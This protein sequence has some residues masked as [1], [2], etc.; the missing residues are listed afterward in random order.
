MKHTGFNDEN[1]WLE[2]AD[3]AAEWNVEGSYDAL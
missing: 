1:Q 2:D 3:L